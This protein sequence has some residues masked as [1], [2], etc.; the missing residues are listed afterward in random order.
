[1]SNGGAVLL[2]GGTSGIG[3]GIADALVRSGRPVMVVGRDSDRCEHAK[4]ALSAYGEADSFP[5]DTTDPV[6]LR[7]ALDLLET[8]WGPVGGLVTAAGQIARGS[9]GEI[10]VDQLR[11][12]LDVN[13]VGTWLAIQTVLP[14]MASQLFGRIVTIGSVLGTVGSVERGAYS[15]TKGAVA[16]MTRSIALE[17]AAQGVTVNCV[18]PG[19]VRT[20]M[21]T[22]PGTSLDPGAAE[23]TSR[24]PV[25]TWGTPADVAHAALALLAP[26]AGWTTGAV[27]HVDGGYTAI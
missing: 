13:V 15:A 24:I 10:G 16:S 25:G 1:V 18:A 4:A 23:F 2:T 17:V 6:G 5:C 26:D 8:K 14:S 20:P 3:L 19:P 11:Q 7:A 27:L 9:V 21:N 12:V 22:P